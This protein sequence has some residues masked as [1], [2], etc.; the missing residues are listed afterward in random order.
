MSFSELVVAIK[1]RT[2]T[3]QQLS[4]MADLVKLFKDAGDL[5]MF[6]GSKKEASRRLK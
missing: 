6:V 4:G 5:R 2:D 3:G 1:G